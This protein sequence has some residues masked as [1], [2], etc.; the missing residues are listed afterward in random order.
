M[1]RT[2]TRY[3]VSIG[4]LY[5]VDPAP[6]DT[7]IKLTSNAHTALKFVTFE[8]ACQIAKIAAERAEFEPRVLSCD[9]DY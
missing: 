9:Y 5:L 2:R 3:L 8:R 1:N 7:S 6:D 4:D